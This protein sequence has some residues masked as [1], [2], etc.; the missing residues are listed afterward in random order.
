MSDGYREAFID[1]GYDEAKVGLD[2]EGSHHSTDRG[3][4]V[5]D[6]GR[7]ELIDNQGWIDIKVVKEH[8]RAFVIHRVREAFTRRG[9]A[10]QTL[11]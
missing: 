11:R 1:M 2:Y 10:P 3:Q 4:Y 8:S 5:H 6:I 9:W 7:T